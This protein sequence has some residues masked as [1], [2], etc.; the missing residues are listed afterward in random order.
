MKHP[1]VLISESVR[2]HIEQKHGI[3]PEH[4]HEGIENAEVWRKEGSRYHAETRTDS[5][6]QLHIII[7][8]VRGAWEVVSSWWL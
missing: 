8:R 1:P 3:L 6:K 2:L 4:V 5:G 7:D